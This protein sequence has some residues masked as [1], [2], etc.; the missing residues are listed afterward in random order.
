MDK[1]NYSVDDLVQIASFRRMVYGTASPEEIDQWNSWVEEDDRNREK[2]REAAARIVGFEFSDPALPNIEKEWSR[3]YWST[4]GAQEPLSKK[5][6]IDRES[7]LV[8]I[9]RAAA[10]LLLITTVGLGVYLYHKSNQA[11]PST[12][13]VAKQQTI[14]TGQGEQATLK[15]SNGSQIIL[16]SNSMLTYPR[17]VLQNQTIKVTLRGEAFFHVDSNSLNKKPVFAVTT[18]D[19][20]IRDIGTKFLVTVS[21][22][23]S[24]V[25]LQ[26]GRV[27]VKT[28]D[29][30]NSMKEFEVIKGELVE[31]S[32]SDIVKKEFTNTTFYTSWATGFL[33]FDQTGIHQFS[34]YV[35]RRFDVSVKVTD[36]KLENVTL[37][38]AVYFKSL[39]GLVWSVSDVTGVPV[40]Q[41]KDKKTVYIGNP[42]KAVK[43][44][45]N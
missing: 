9:F 24:R 34:D 27:K 4:V 35:E 28:N 45:K 32:A 2:A 40:Y 7:T 14:S 25:V 6:K 43:T 33:Q 22:D 39:E 26:E 11:K 42:S 16:N 20:T 8:P 5:K 41:S 38:G 18:P 13:Q 15:F 29:V 12:E 10:I 1:K 23:H 3:L 19:G 17:N 37:E 44:S 31:F 30:K 21:K 36:P